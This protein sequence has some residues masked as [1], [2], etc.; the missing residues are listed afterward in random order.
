[1]DEL[2][3]AIWSA[4]DARALPEK[5]LRV[6]RLRKTLATLSSVEFERRLVAISPAA[7][8]VL[9]EAVLGGRCDFHTAVRQMFMAAMADPEG[10]NLD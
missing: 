5:Q 7:V 1:V 6:S 2:L 8:D 9:C 3:D 4:G 10:E